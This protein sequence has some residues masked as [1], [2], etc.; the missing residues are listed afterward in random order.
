MNNIDIHEE[1]I[2]TI[3]HSICVSIIFDNDIDDE[4][5]KSGLDELDFIKN[6]FSK[7]ELMNL[8]SN[9]DEETIMD[10]IVCGNAEYWLDEFGI[11]DIENY[12]GYHDINEGIARFC[13]IMGI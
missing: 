10:D 6:H 8:A 9:I 4:F 5:E 7:E 3:I 13:D 11:R 1:I 12:M 2:D